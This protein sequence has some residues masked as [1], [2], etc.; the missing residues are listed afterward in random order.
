[1]TESL[2][3]Q[4]DLKLAMA[5]LRRDLLAEGGPQISTMRNYRFAILPYPPTEE[6][7]L[8][9]QVRALTDDLEA[10]GWVV[11]TL[12]L[13]KLMMDRLRQQGGDALASVVAR[14]KRLYGRST[15]RALEHLKETVVP[16][17]EGPD[18]IAADVV[19]VIGDFVDRNPDK[20]DTSLVL[21][22]R[23]G[24]L[25]PFYRSSALLKHIDGQTRGV[26]VVVLYPGERVDLSA[27]KFMGQLEP[28]RDYRPRIYP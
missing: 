21:L 27:L 19:R 17:I 4:T 15:A 3:Y 5:A 20:T 18:G 7:A 10:N 11:L 12:S 26:P 22:G 23:L 16:L 2:L 28:D 1:M 14:E 9:A 8:R 24:A 25:Y 6:F 13:Q